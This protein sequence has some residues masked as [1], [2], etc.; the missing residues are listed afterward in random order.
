MLKKIWKRPVGK[1]KYCLRPY[2]NKNSE[3]AKKELCIYCF[4]AE[5]R[6]KSLN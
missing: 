3:W 4:E 1:C 2:F 6:G 5:E